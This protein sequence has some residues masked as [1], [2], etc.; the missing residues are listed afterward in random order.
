MV[1]G[2]GRTDD[3]IQFR[4]KRCRIVVIRAL[5]C[6]VNVFYREPCFLDFVVSIGVLETDENRIGVFNEVAE[7]FESYLAFFPLS[8]SPTPAPGNPDNWLIP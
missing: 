6:P 1:N 4:D 8:C 5:H 3:E 7:G 2:R